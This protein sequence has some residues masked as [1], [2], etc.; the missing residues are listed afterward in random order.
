[1]EI[2]IEDLAPMRVAYIQHTGPY[3][4]CCQ[5]WGRLYDWATRHKFITPGTFGIG[6]SYD[7]PETTP[8]EKSRYDACLTCSENFEPNG[9][10]SVQTL[11]GGKYVTAVHRGPYKGLKNS[12]RRILKDWLPKSGRN[13]RDAPCLELYIDDPDKTPEP[14]LRTKICVPIE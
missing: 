12:F 13:L 8:P 9:E 4:T 1:M 11:G 14:D 5:A 6:A 3:E 10:V 7:D 2:R